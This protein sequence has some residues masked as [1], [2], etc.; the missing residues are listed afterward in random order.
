MP[1]AP[2]RLVAAPLCSRIANEGGTSISTLEH[3][4]AAFRVYGITNALITLDGPEVPILDGSALPWVRAIE[5]AGIFEQDC[6]APMVE[7]R[8]PVRVSYDDRHATLIPLQN[9]EETATFT[10]RIEFA[11]IGIGAQ[12]FSGEAKPA[13][14]NAEIA[15]ARSFVEASEL[16]ALQSKGLVRGGSLANAVVFDAVGVRNPEGL[17]FPD[18]PARHKVLDAMGDMYLGG[19]ADPCALSGVQG[20]SRLACGPAAR[21]VRR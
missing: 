7:L 15:A 2:G 19:G 10:A 8:R 14:F 13:F 9:R 21:P 16:P 20:G 3:L 5:E 1:V 12:S 18:E 6:V 11:S 17:R 4:M